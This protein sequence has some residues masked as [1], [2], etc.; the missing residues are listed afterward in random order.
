MKIRLALNKFSYHEKNTE[1]VP[2]QVYNTE[3]IP[4]QIFPPNLSFRCIM[5]NTPPQ[6]YNAEH[7]PPNVNVADQIPPS[8]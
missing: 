2:L 6:I 4:P 8:N 5:R 1:H 3:Q 7:I